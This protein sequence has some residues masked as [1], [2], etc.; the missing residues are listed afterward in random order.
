MGDRWVAVC[1]RLVPPSL[2]STV[3]EPAV[4]DLLLDYDERGRGASRLRR[5]ALTVALASAILAAALECR[6]LH[7]APAV[8]NRGVALW[9][10]ARAAAR[11]LRRAPALTTVVVHLLGLGIGVNVVVFSFANTYLLASLPVPDADRLVRV[12]GRTPTRDLDVVSYPF[13]RGVRDAATGLALAAHAEAPVRI[14]PASSGLESTAELVTGNFFQVMA[15]RP[16][17]GRLIAPADDLVE[18]A[19]PVVVIGETLWRAH[20]NA[21]ASLI[22]RTVLVNGAPFTVI[23]IAPAS[24]RGAASAYAVSDLWAPLAMHDQIRPRGATRENADWGWLSMI[25]R[26]ADG[27]TTAIAEQELATVAANLNR[28]V[29]PEYVTSLDVLPASALPESDRRRAVSVLAVAGGMTA[30]VLI[31]ACANLAG[32]MQTRVLDRRRELA[33]R[34]ALGAAPSHLIRMLVIEALIVAGVAGAAGLA[35]GRLAAA[36]IERW[37]PPAQLIGDMSFHTSLDWRVLVFA[38]AVTVLCAAAFALL[39][40]MSAARA[41]S[42]AALK[43]DGPTSTGGRHGARFRRVAVVVQVSSA[44]VLLVAGGLMV[45]SAIALSRVDPG[46]EPGN[47][48]V[49]NVD[50]RRG[51]VPGDE[52]RRTIEAA[53]DRLR[54]AAGVQA[55]GIANAVPLGVEKNRMRIQV[56]G[57]VNPDGTTGESI[58][59]AQVGR[60]YFEAIGIPIR[61]GAV[62]T[63]TTESSAGNVVVINETMARQFWSGRDPVGTRIIVVGRGPATVVAVARDSVYYELGEAPRPFMYIPA[64]TAL[65]E[66]LAVIVRT[67]TPVRAMLAALAREIALV[68]ERIAPLA[69]TSFDALRQVPLYPSRAFASIALVFGALALLLTAVGL[70]GVVAGVVGQRTREFGVRLA[71]G[72]RGAQIVGVVLRDALLLAG[73]GVVAGLAAGRLVSDALGSWL[74]GVTAVDPATYAAVAG[75]VVAVT[76]AAAWIPAR[77]AARIDPVTALRG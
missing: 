48:A 20:F 66:S 35:G 49:F 37:R 57:Y 15:A 24:F 70:Y 28:G 34:R 76:M 68:D 6:R 40:A 77:R 22:G 73:I 17:A 19:H 43:D 62:W 4:A 2:H 47:L 7:V 27:P 29:A 61:R 52:R 51:R 56:P 12:Y 58:A 71:L 54:G 69:S 39:P 38:V 74:F 41:S 21:D 9:T 42:S 23:G 33:L 46:F 45:R 72:A 53:L 18:G 59:Y 36:L 63:T 60:T 50:F 75:I 11:A 55:A 16:V 67:T 64:E 13:Y 5:A 30:L 44:I 8:R 3:F 14:G 65:P 10:D 1:A 31:A 25:G 26:L 32:V